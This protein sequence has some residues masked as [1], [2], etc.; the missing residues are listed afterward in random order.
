M[1]TSLRKC[2]YFSCIYTNRIWIWLEYTPQIF[3]CGRSGFQSKG[4]EVKEPLRDDDWWKV[5][6]SWNRFFLVKIC[7][8]LMEHPGSY[9]CEFLQNRLFSWLLASHLIMWPLLCIHSYHC[10]D[11]CHESCT[12]VKQIWALCSWIS[13]VMS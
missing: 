5:N 3:I 4:A 13:I 9:R 10:G 6:R 7:A 8:D 12:R 1:Y 2:F 11:T